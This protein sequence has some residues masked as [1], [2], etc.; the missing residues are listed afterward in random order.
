[1][2]TRLSLWPAVE[3]EQG[4]WCIHARMQNLQKHCSWTIQYCDN[5]R[6]SHIKTAWK[7]TYKADNCAY[8]A[9]CQS[10]GFQAKHKQTGNQSISHI[11][12]CKP[13]H[14]NNQRPILGQEKW[15]LKSQWKHST[16]PRTLGIL[17]SGKQNLD[18]CFLQMSLGQRSG[19]W[20]NQE[21]RQQA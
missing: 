3:E 16:L 6:S 19:S 13:W 10:K 15:K 1:M 20:Q 7:V 21:D 4:S 2:Q 18:K 11:K 14:K 8:T 9:K 17:N 5:N 12:L